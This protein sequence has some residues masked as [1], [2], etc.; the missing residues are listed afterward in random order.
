MTNEQKLRLQSKVPWMIFVNTGMTS[1]LRDSLTSLPLLALLDP[2]LHTACFARSPICERDQNKIRATWG[3]PLHVNMC[4][5]QFFFPLL[6]HIKQCHTPPIAYG[7]E[8]LCGGMN[9]INEMVESLPGHYI[10]M[11]HWTQFDKTTPV[12]LIRDAFWNLSKLIDWNN[13]VDSKSQVWLFKDPDSPAH[14][15]PAA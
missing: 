5:G 15:H 11:G 12:C 13:I 7:L 1:S 10:L 8:I 9:H 3:Y 4:E 6:E 14:H 2:P